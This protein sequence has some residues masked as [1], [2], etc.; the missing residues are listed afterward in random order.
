MHLRVRNGRREAVHD[1]SEDEARHHTPISDEH[2]AYQER[3]VR[4]AEAAGFQAESEVRTLTGRRGW[5]QTDTLVDAGNGRR[6]GWEVQLSTAGREGPKSVL[7]R[8]KKA[9]LN[10]IIP[11][12]HTDRSDYARRNDTQWTMSNRLPAHVIAKIGD[13]RV[14]SGF[15]VLDFYQCDLTADYPCLYGVQRCG[16][17]HAWPKPRDI[18]F[19]DLVRDTAAGTVVPFEHPTPTRTN[20]FWISWDDH[21]RYQDSLSASDGPGAHHEAGTR[22]VHTNLRAPTC[23][24]VPAQRPHSQP[25]LDWSAPSRWLDEPQPCRHCRK[26]AHL[27]D[28]LGLPSHKVCAEASLSGS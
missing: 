6:I 8:A 11:A 5:I 9:R 15:R 24:P 2:K 27:V 20:R 12:W 23:R 13:L 17:V 16:K 7:A 28:D 1:R 3:I 4:T 21:A 14:V 25:V 22:P 26:P 10:G 18:M 19:D